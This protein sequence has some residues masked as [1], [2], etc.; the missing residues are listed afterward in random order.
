MNITA[1]AP[2]QSTDAPPDWVD[3]LTDLRGLRLAIYDELIRLAE[4]SEMQ[5]TASL[6]CPEEPQPTR[7]EARAEGAVAR[8]L[9]WL[10]HHRLAVRGAS[11]RWTPRGL[12]AACHLFITSGPDAAYPLLAPA[13]AE[14]AQKGRGDRRSQGQVAHAEVAGAGTPPKTHAPAAPRPAIHAPQFFDFGDY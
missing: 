4:R 13:T 6:S 12:A 3:V 9:A 8:A 11:G 2:D 7:T 1:L 5:L 14:A 10:G